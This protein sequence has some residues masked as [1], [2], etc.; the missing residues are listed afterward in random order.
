MKCDMIQCQIITLLMMSS[1]STLSWTILPLVDGKITRLIAHEPNN[2]PIVRT[3]NENHAIQLQFTCYS[4][5][6]NG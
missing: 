5:L 6:V 2:S 1:L 3:D 4:C